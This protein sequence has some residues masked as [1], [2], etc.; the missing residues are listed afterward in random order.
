M[1]SFPPVQSVVRALK[2]LKDLNTRRVTTVNNTKPST[3][4]TEAPNSSI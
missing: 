1:P 3:P 4:A 2:I